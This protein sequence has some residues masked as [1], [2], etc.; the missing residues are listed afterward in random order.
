MVILD[1]DLNF[2]AMKKIIT[3]LSYVYD[4]RVT[5]GITAFLLLLAFL[6]LMVL[7]KIISDIE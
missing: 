7:G 6:G 3:F 5:I 1:L 2:K 4:N